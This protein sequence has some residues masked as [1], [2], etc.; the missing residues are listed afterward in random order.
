[1]SVSKMFTVERVS[2]DDI[3]FTE[4]TITGSTYEP[5]GQVFH[6]GQQVNCSS[7]DYEA[8]TEVAT[9]CSLCNDSSVD[10]NEVDLSSQPSHPHR[11]SVKTR[12]REGW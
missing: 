1:M 8:L 7:G 10:Y 5:V 4:F 11:F 3:K 9:I 6:N 2:G 12:L